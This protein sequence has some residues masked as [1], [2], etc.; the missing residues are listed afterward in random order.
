MGVDLAAH[1]LRCADINNN[2]EDEKEAINYDDVALVHDH[3]TELLNKLLEAILEN[4]LPSSSSDA[5]TS[6]GLTKFPA[7]INYNVDEHNCGARLSSDQTNVSVSSTVATSDHQGTYNELL[8]RSMSTVSKDS[9]DES[10][11]NSNSSSASSTY[12]LSKSHLFGDRKYTQQEI[13]ARVKVIH[14]SDHLQERL[15]ERG[16]NEYD[17]YRTIL[18]GCRCKKGDDRIKFTHNET[19]VITD[20]EVKVGITMYQEKYSNKDCAQCWSLKEG[21]LCACGLCRGCCKSNYDDKYEEKKEP[22]RTDVGKTLSYDEYLAQKARP[23]SEAFKPLKSRE[24][25]NEFAGKPT[26]TL[27]TEDFLVMGS[28]KGPLKKG[29]CLKNSW[30]KCQSKAVGTQVLQTFDGIN[31]KKKRGRKKLKCI[32]KIIVQMINGTRPIDSMKEF[33]S[34]KAFAI[35]NEHRNFLHIGSYSDQKD[36]WRKYISKR[37]AIRSKEGKGRLAKIHVPE[38]DGMS[39]GF[40]EK[41]PVLSFNYYIY[42]RDIIMCHYC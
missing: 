23:H 25:D 14:F 36:I 24:V 31:M 33:E 11:T 7:P 1:M 2:T 16:L 8:S 19:T 13:E 27:E 34:D 22:E 5:D 4:D 12:A 41:N 10:S 30:S 37:K 15:Y 20:G 28:G 29:F 9:D 21:E 38:P 26:M 40:V 18:Y 32:T 6:D 35:V 42:C 3:Q 17:V 39:D